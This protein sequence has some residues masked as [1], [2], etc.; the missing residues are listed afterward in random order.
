MAPHSGVGAWM[1]TPI[2]AKVALMRT[3]HA[4]R[5]G[6]CAVA[7]KM[8][9]GRMCTHI[10]RQAGLPTAMAACTKVDDRKVNTS[11]RT[12]RAKIG[13]SSKP[14]TTTMLTKLWPVAA[15]TASAK[16]MVGNARNTSKVRSNTS[17]SQPPL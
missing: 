11:A 3:A 6:S 2:K 14:M 10:T 15:T 4:I 16:M 5:M 8:A 1:P 7:P 17:S 9:L 13:L 12:T